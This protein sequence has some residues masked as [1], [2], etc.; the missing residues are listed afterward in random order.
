MIPI[1]TLLSVTIFG[2]ASLQYVSS[3]ACP[4][5]PNCQTPEVCFAFDDDPSLLVWGPCEGCP[6]GQGTCL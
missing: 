4:Q 2:T 5:I 3:F 1:K 6:D